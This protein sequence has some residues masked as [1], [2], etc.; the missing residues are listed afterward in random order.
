MSQWS[1]IGFINAASP[2]IEELIF[3]HDYVIMFLILITVSVWYITI[4]FLFNSYTCR[5]VTEGQT[6]ETIWTLVPALILL[7]LA[8]P[9]LQL[10]YLLDEV[11]NPG[12]TV[13]RIGHQWYWSYEYD[14]FH[15][16]KFDRYICPT[17][18]LEKGHYRLLEVDNRAVIPVN[19]DVRVLV[20]SGDVIHSWT[21]P[22][23]GIK[24]DAVPGRLNQ[25]GFLCKSTGVYYG[26]CSEIC[27]ANHSFIPIVVEV[28]SL[29]VFIKWMGLGN[30]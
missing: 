11:G 22:A 20:T 7:V 1:S 27:G 24:V 28:V 2:L 14:D 19:T 23:L 26:Q 25:L 21:V 6:I 12:L 13:K 15:G 4:C 17:S 3:F 9:S 10:L 5:S 8:L 18:D 16:I 30:A 29:P